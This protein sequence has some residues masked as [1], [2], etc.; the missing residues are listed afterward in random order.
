MTESRVSGPEC[1]T[2]G[3]DV[4]PRAASQ[5]TAN[6]PSEPMNRTTD[7]LQALTR[8]RS[9]RPMLVLGCGETHRRAVVLDA[10]RV[11]RDCDVPMGPVARALG[12]SV[13][14]LSQLFSLYGFA[15]RLPSHRTPWAAAPRRRYRVDEKRFRRIESE[16]DAYWLGFLAADGYPTRDGVRLQLSVRDQ[17]HVVAFARF[18]G[19]DAPVRLVKSNGFPH[20][21]LDVYSMRVRESLQALGLYARRSETNAPVPLVPTHLEHHFWRGV[22]DGDGTIVRDKRV[23]DLLSRWALGVCGS[24]AVVDAFGEYAAR[25]IGDGRKRKDTRNGDNP[26]NRKLLLNGPAALLVM[27]AIYADATLSLTRKRKRAEPI[28]AAFSE[29]LAKGWVP[30]VQGDRLCWQKPRVQPVSLAHSL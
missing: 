24:S 18:M 30:A 17:A 5:A 14:W 21:R 2:D 15:S 29:R 11:Y 4:L 26:K 28:I 12:R 1:S 19:T 23:K 3:A 16:A 27:R 9:L 20:V 22:F 6:R 7:G 25:V 8:L 13:P 10:Y